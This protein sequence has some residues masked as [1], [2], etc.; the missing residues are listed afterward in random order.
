MP[1]D[2]ANGNPGNIDLLS[3]REGNSPLARTIQTACPSRDSVLA[4]E[5][6]AA[7]PVDNFS[8]YYSFV[9]RDHR[10]QVKPIDPHRSIEPLTSSCA[11]TT[12]RSRLCGFQ[13]IIYQWTQKLVPE[14]RAFVKRRN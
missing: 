12:L 4:A 14:R 6:K 2:A 9:S 7:T 1:G 10:L 13:G 11:L 3:V 8:V 5:F